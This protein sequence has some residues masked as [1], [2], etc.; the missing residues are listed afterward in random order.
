[1]Q[2]LLLELAPPPEPTLENFV[3]GR[4]AAA[5]RAI[6]DIASGSGAERFIY[7]WGDPG[8]GRSHLLRALDRAAA[9]RVVI[10]DDVHKLSDEAQIALFDDYN[11]M[12]AAGGALV[13]GGSAAPAH[14]PLREDLRSRLAWGLAFQLHPLSD[15]EKAAALRARAGERSLHLAEDV[16]AH[17]LRHAPRDMASLTGIVD[18]LDRYS[19]EQKRPVTLPLLRDALNRLKQRAA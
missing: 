9:G 11:R 5:L 16:I 13:A 3:P 18:A 12:R 6:Q 17:L 19:L 15:D 1:M 4:N 8:S 10:A 2:Q 14:L 7:L